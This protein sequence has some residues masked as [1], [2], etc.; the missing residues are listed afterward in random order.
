LKLFIDHWAN[1]LNVIQP[2]AFGSL[3]PG[4]EATFN[5]NTAVPSWRYAK[6]FK[7]QQ[8]TKN[9]K[10][11]SDLD[12][13]LLPFKVRVSSL[14]R[15]LIKPTVIDEDPMMPDSRDDQKA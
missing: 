2:R 3:Q 6:S 8:E 4:N 1:V 9:Q 15:D 10:V 14:S 7:N 5:A 13:E 12:Y 11:S